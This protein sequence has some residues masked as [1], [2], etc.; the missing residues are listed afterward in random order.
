MTSTPN[1]RRAVETT[2]HVDEL[3]RYLS[4]VHWK[5]REMMDAIERWQRDD[6]DSVIVVFGDHLPLLGQNL[7]GYAES[8][9]LGGADDH[10]SPEIQARATQ[11]PILVIDGRNGPLAGGPVCRCTAC[12]PAARS[13]RPADKGSPISRHPR[14]ARSPAAARKHRRL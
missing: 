14:R 5:S 8:G 3:A 12:R 11:T 13:R 10:V 2:T 7:A 4:V 9:F 1:A 6:P